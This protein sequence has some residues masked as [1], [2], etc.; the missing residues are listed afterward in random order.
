[1]STYDATSYGRWHRE[2]RGR[3]SAAGMVGA[4]LARRSAQW[5]PYDVGGSV[6][7]LTMH[8]DGDADSLTARIYVTADGS[9]A[10][11]VSG[12]SYAGLP[13]GERPT[14]RVDMPLCRVLAVPMATTTPDRHPDHMSARVY[15]YDQ[16]VAALH[17]WLDDNTNHP[18]ARRRAQE[19]A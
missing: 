15:V 8:I 19:G 6:L 10:E 17:A 3:P 5:R 18:A 4:A 9:P 13:L 2:Q 11:F 1:M 14:H 12:W 16:A 7:G